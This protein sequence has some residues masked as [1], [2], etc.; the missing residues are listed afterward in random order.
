MYIPDT[1]IKKSVADKV[2][3]SITILLLIATAAF[4]IVHTIAE[5][6]QQKQGTAPLTLSATKRD[7]D[8]LLSYLFGKVGREV[9]EQAEK[10]VNDI[11]EYRVRIAQEVEKNNELA[12]AFYPLTEG[13]PKR[14]Q[15]EYWKEIDTIRE[16]A[17]KHKDAIVPLVQNDVFLSEAVVEKYA[18][19]PSFAEWLLSQ[20][21]GAG[22]VE[23]LNKIQKDSQDLR[24]EIALLYMRIKTVTGKR[25]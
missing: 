8:S 18:L 24:K 3:L 14:M 16:K 19:H 17:T 11:D 1:N 15:T 7:H 6:G 23:K 10:Y 13:F 9:P 21:H 25:I 2:V 12:S 4:P 22:K 5:T 20:L